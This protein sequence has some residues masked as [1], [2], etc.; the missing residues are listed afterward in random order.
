MFSIRLVQLIEAHA[1]KLSQGLMQRLETSAQCR[2]LLR[3]V[4]ADELKQRAREIYRNL[5]D[6]L[7]TKTDSEIEERYIGLGIRRARQGVPFS[8]F[9]SAITITKE[10]LWEHLEREGLLEEPVEL[11]GE[12]ELLHTLDRFFDRA[13]YFAAL[14]YES[15]KVNEPARRAGAPVAVRR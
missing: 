8:Q 15:A 1:D 2:D 7:L 12:M 11:L 9:F 13:L 5:S 4:P 14:G 10:Y 6:W 3:K